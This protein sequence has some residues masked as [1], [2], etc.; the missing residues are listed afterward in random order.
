L[1][2]EAVWIEAI[3]RPGQVLAHAVEAEAEKMLDLRGSAP[4]AVELA[5]VASYILPI[6]EA[7]EAI[8]PK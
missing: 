6:G 8:V 4:A 2:S 5:S 3:G 1:R 7:G